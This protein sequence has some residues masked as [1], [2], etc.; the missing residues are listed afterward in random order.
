MDGSLTGG[1]FNE[2]SHEKYS[3]KLYLFLHSYEL[4]ALFFILF[5]GPKRQPYR[6]GITL[7]V[8]DALTP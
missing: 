2:A 8:F 7:S 4:L 1:R 6:V 3:G 5:R